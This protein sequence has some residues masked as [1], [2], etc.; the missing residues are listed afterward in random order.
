MGVVSR[1]VRLWEEDDVVFHGIFELELIFRRRFWYFFLDEKMMG[2][3]VI[4]YDL[5]PEKGG[6]RL[7][8]YIY[9]REGEG[10]KG[11]LSYRSKGEGEE[12]EGGEG[13]GIKMVKRVDD[14]M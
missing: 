14:E 3:T 10:R 1:L 11:V 13:E 6:M 12:E 7:G 2:C 4:L 5:M 9:K 8:K